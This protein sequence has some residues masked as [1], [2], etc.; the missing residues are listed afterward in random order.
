MEKPFP[1]NRP[2]VRLLAALLGKRKLASDRI[3]FDFGP[4]YPGPHTITAGGV[5]KPIAFNKGYFYSVCM[6]REHMKKLKGWQIGRDTLLE[7]AALCAEHGSR[8]IVVYMPAKLTVYLDYVL[9]LFD[10]QRILDYA[11]PVMRELSDIN[12]DRFIRM[13]NDNWNVQ[14]EVLKEFCDAHD[15]E[16]IDTTPALR[17]S[18]E[19]GEWPYY[20]YDTHMNIVGQHV[21]ADV[22]C[23]YLNATE[24]PAPSAGGTP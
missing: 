3:Q 13:L 15:I 11:R 23:S 20:C 5:E 19:R 2:A 7:A 14:Y 18:L 22:V 6:P 10:K 9:P 8:L 12:A 24:E 4:T 16:I 17:A 1:Y 21:V